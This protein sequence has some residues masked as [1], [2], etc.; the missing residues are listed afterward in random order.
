MPSPIYKFGP[1]ELDSSRFELRCGDRPLKLEPIPT[2]L[3]I[4]LLEKKGQVVS[5]PEIIER[6]WGKDVFLDTEHGINTSV[7]KI[8]RVIK[9]DVGRPRFIQTISGKGYRFLPDEVTTN[10]EGTAASVKVLAP[11]DE[12]LTPVSPFPFEAAVTRVVEDHVENSAPTRGRII[13]LVGGLSLA[14]VLVLAVWS[15]S[16]R[17]QNNAID[18]IAVLPFSA[19]SDANTEYLTD[20][21]AENLIAALSQL[22]NVRVIA[23]STMFRYKG[24]N[25]DPQTVGR[26]L[27]VHA[28]LSGRLI[29][30][31]D[32]VILQAELVDVKKG[33]RIWGGQYSRKAGDIFALQEDLSRAISEQ[34]GRRLTGE[35]K[36]LLTRRYTANAEAYQFYLRGRYFWNK[37]TP[38]GYQQAIDYYERAIIKDPS[39][40]L[41]YSGLS[42]AY[43]TLARDVLP[44]WEAG[45]KS[46]AAAEKAVELDDKI[47]E[48]HISLGWVNMWYA[49]DWSAAG[50]NLRSAIALNP[51][52]PSAHDIYSGYLCAMGRYDESLAEATRA[53]ELDPAS[54][55]MMLILGQRF[56][57][58]KH[59]DQAI[60]QFTKVLEMDPTLPDARLEL[61]LA[62]AAKKQFR[63]SLAEF[64]RARPSPRS[65]AYR[66]YAHAMLHER[67]HAL[68]S[69][70]ELRTLAK[71]RYVSS[72][73]FAVV[74][75]GLGNKDHVFK[76]LEKARDD[77]YI[78]IPWL[79]QSSIFEPLQ[80]DSRFAELIHPI[81][82]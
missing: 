19:S 46:K 70:N 42:D 75:M 66:G 26:E 64:E 47:A 4:L 38:E 12:A 51:A 49:W 18:S 53:V 69:L 41:A 7:R 40:A 36:Q 27:E 31:G 63:E 15:I 54:P 35:Q 50:Q 20:G 78:Y 14:T 81:G 13:L 32:S 3:L 43:N 2:K 73:F 72:Y 68:R 10:S 45:P 34:L 30:S 58:A 39:Y 57:C 11:A 52:N 67:Q 82:N 76:D 22:P 61:G 9:E 62:Y 56:T 60:Q 33:F 79:K 37:W 28:V 24:K 25:I 74:Y 59:F 65:I 5:R 21:I 29:E 23:R 48:A 71:E 55:S 6:L 1:Y 80:S 17:Q 44:P 77:H 16:F 8:R